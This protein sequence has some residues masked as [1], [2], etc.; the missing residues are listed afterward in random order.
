MKAPTRLDYLIGWLREKQYRLFEFVLAL[1]ERWHWLHKYSRPWDLL[2]RLAGHGC[3]QDG[4]REIG[5]PCYLPD[6]YEDDDAERPT[7]DEPS[8]YYC[9][10]HAQRNG[11][12]YRCGQFW[13]GVES[14]DFGPGYCDNCEQYEDHDDERDEWDGQDEYDYWEQGP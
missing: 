3:Q 12:C 11:F 7:G 8:A 5:I 13:E 2:E 14:F 6:L 4:C 1:A 9:G 10:A